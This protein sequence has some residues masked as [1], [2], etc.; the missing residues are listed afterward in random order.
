M[1]DLSKMTT[2]DLITEMTHLDQEIDIKLFRYEQLRQEVFRR[3]P[4]VQNSG[5]FPKKVKKL[6]GL[7]DVKNRINQSYR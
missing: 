4:K 3:F 1:D 2:V 5:E 7:E 6:G